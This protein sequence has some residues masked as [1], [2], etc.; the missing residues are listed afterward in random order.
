MRRVSR[1][2]LVCGTF[3][4]AAAILYIGT[5]GCGPYHVP[6]PPTYY[7]E[8]LA[9]TASESGVEH[10]DTIT[11]HR[12]A[13]I[14][15]VEDIDYEPCP[16][17]EVMGLKVAHLRAALVPPEMLQFGENVVRISFYLSN[18]TDA[19]AHVRLKSAL[20]RLSDG[21]EIA[22]LPPLAPEGVEGGEKEVPQVPGTGRVAR[23]GENPFALD[24]GTGRELAF[25][26]AAGGQTR[27]VVAFEI[28]FT[29]GRRRYVLAADY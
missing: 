2:R 25:D 20:M 23:L 15:G 10:T 12:R 14:R 19:P 5:M 9:L 1:A 28:E 18:T 17:V 24:P 26:F 6:L 21:T 3:I 4:P 8:T 16:S 13:W 22:I 29:E 7:P 11:P 27:T